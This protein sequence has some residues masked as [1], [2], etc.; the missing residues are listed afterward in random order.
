VA[1]G[2][3]IGPGEKIVAVNGRSY[4]GQDALDKGIRVA[5][6]AGSNGEPVRLL[7]S[8]GHVYRT[9]SMLY[10]GGPRYPH[11]VRIAGTP[12]VLGAIAAPL[13]L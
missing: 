8:A 5:L 11:L 4:D 2:A 3:G 6:H 7:L 9:V 10:R 1:F 13:K 12:D